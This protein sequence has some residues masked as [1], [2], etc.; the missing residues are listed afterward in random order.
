MSK[1]QYELNHILIFCSNT[2]N[3][4]SSM[5]TKFLLHKCKNHNNDQNEV[6][7]SNFSDNLADYTNFNACFKNLHL[8]IITY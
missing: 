5:K 1:A 8:F 3:L 2:K 6:K 7:Y 4:D